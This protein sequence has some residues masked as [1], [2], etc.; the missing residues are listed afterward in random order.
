MEGINRDIVRFL[1]EAGFCGSYKREIPTA[2][3]TFRKYE[4]KGVTLYIENKQID[5]VED[6]HANSKLQDIRCFED[7]AEIQQV[8][9]LF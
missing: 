4:S 5:H 9:E 1:L 6:R 7:K 8:A 3:Q 2:E